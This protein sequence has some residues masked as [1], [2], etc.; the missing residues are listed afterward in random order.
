MLAGS[1][2]HGKGGIGMDKFN[3]YVPNFLPFKEYFVPEKNQACPGCGLALAIR[4]SYKALDKDIE[5]AIWQPLMVDKPFERA[6]DLFGVGRT[7]VSFLRIPK[8]KADLILCLDNEAEGSLNDALEKPMPSIAVAGGF[9][10]VATAC[11]SYPF[12][13]Y[14]KIK[15]G[16]GIEGR[17]YIHILCPCPE[18]WQFEP[19]LTVKIGHWAVESRAFPLYEVGGGVYHLT[20]E[21]PKSRSLD[22][23]LR[24]QKRFESLSEDEITEA[25]LT[26]EHNYKKVVD[27]VQKYL[28]ATGVQTTPQ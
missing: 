20:I 22:G 5:K 7:E 18:G 4:Q 17:A 19:E 10:Y 13:L 12:D 27:A 16:I 28:D 2:Q 23:Y 21:T 6:L 9:Q 8:G 3:L 24:A 11:P 26:V 14:G 25:Q 15:R 1:H